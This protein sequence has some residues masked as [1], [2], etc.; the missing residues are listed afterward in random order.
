[1][2]IVKALLYCNEQCHMIVD[3]GATISCITA[4]MAEALGIEARIEDVVDLILPNAIHI[5]V[6]RLSVSRIAVDG[7]QAD[8]IEA[9]VL[10]E[11]QPGIDGCLDQ[12]FL[13]RF[14]YHIDI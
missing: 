11:A 10:S 12:S 13:N 1:M 9:A 2:L 5:K 6:P 8:N 3:T 7:M 14:E 4:E